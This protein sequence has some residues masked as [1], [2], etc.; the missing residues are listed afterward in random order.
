[1]P[2]LTGLSV[3]SF[4]ATFRLEKA[5]HLLFNTELLVKDI[6]YQTGFNSTDYF[7]KLYKEKF[8][9]TPGQ[10]RNMDPNNS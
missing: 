1:M 4:I 5:Q 2:A 8:G 10:D 9:K 7:G 6:A 3:S